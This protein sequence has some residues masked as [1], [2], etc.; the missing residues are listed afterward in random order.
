MMLLLLLLPMFF[1]NVATFALAYALA[2]FV[3]HGI[4]DDPTFAFAFATALVVVPPSYA[5]LSFC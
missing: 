5:L 3:A 1:V 4:G 2:P